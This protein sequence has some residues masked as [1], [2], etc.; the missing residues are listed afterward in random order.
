VRVRRHSNA[1]EFLDRAENWLVQSEVENGTLYALARGLLRDDSRYEPP[2]YL[3]TVE[4]DREILGC[5]ART[6]PFPVALSPLPAESIES[7]LEAVRDVYGSVPGVIGPKPEAT[8]FADAWTANSD[9]I[10]STRFQLRSHTL[11]EVVIPDPSPSGNLR[12]ATESEIGLANR[13]REGFERDAGID[14]LPDFGGRTIGEGKLYFWDDNEPRCMVASTRDTPNV[15]WIN[16]VYTPPEFRGCGYA[17]AAVAALSQRLLEQG[18]AFCALY[19]DL[20]NPTSNKI[21][22]RVGYEPVGDA[23]ELEFSTPD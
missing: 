7:V 23:V 22:R 14:G 15:A 21:Y 6:P 5:V 16:T 18:W 10:W 4:R 13:W 17:S 12:K 11:S 9:A 1:R 19:T 8:R 20:A 2:I 3:A